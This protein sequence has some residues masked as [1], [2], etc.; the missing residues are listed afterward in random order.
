MRLHEDR[1]EFIEYINQASVYFGVD[2]ALIEKDY[3]VTLFLSRAKEEIP[4]MVF[5]GGTSLSKCH[6]II[7]RFS[8]D[9]DLTLDTEHFTQSPKRTANKTIIR[10]CKDLGLVPTNEEKIWSHREYN[11]FNVAYPI[12]FPSEALKSELK[13]EMTYIQKSYPDETKRMDS[14]I[15][16]F[17]HATGYDD[18]AEEYGLRD[19]EIKVQSLDRTL[20]DKVFA[21]CDYMLRGQTTRQSRHIYDLSRLLTKVELNDELKRLVASVR[22]DRKSNKTCVSAQDGMD[23]PYLLRKVIETDYYRKDY[24]DSTEKLLTKP[25]SYKE[26]IKG[27]AK[28]AES[29]VFEFIHEEKTNVYMLPSECVKTEQKANRKKNSERN[30]K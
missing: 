27:L 21:V 7:D 10:I 23:I 28:I 9:I 2:P 18:V 15:G 26:A 19:F 13:I 14:L 1:E 29:G 8:E 11:C 20:V 3:Y 16:E 24:E 6:K 17:L 4:G 5:K 30:S 25:L 12:L 22:K